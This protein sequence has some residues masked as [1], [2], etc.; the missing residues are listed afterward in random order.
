MYISV[1]IGTFDND[2]VVDLNYIDVFRDSFALRGRDFTHFFIC[3]LL[4]ITHNMPLDLVGYK[5]DC[6]CGAVYGKSL[7]GCDDFYV[8]F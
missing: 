5:V 4:S 8:C 7:A 6:G 2:L 1:E 3:A